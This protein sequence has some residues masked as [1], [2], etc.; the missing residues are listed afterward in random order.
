M[1]LILT[2]FLL[3]ILSLLYLWVKRRFSYWKDLGFLQAE[4]SFPF[5]DPLSA[6]IL[7]LEGQE[8]RDRRVKL[9]PIFTSAKMKM[10]FEIIDSIGD[11]FV[12]S[13]E[14]DMKLSNICEMRQ[15]CQRFTSDNIASTA[16]GLQSNCLE[17]S[18]SQFMK[19]GRRLF[20]LSTF[21]VIKFFASTAWPDLSRKLGILFTPKEAGDFF[22]HTFL[23][24]FE[25][26]TKNPIERHDFVQ[27]LLN[28][29]DTFTPTELAA[30]AFLVYAG[31]FESSSTLM[32]FTLYELAL[33]Q[34]MQDRLRKEL[35]EGIEEN[36]GK[37][38]YDLIFSFK[39]LNMVIQESLRKYPP[40]P[41]TFRKATKDYQFP[42]TNLIIPKGTNIILNTYSL[43]RDPEYFPEPEKFDPE[44]FSAENV[45]NIRPYTMLPFATGPRNCLGERFALMQ[46]KIGITKLITNF[47]F[48]PCDKTTIPMKYVPSAPFL[49]PVNGIQLKV[50]KFKKD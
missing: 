46:S 33:N 24:T 29:K 45:R 32:Q 17:D 26:R 2:V 38:T 25:N 18:N 16:F 3:T 23:Q 4:A 42:D 48:M 39:Y 12:N 22:H 13:L 14:K 36:D 34:D 30:E 41:N 8:W 47:V 15:W 7:T 27:L 21:E 44:R 49:A 19:M 1:D 20:D 43:H 50:E 9:S 28:L 10:M 5:D 6:N 35:I 40:I 31:G 11:K 37:L